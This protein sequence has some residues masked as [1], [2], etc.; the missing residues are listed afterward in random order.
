MANNEWIGASQPRAEVDT[1]TVGGTPAVSNTIAVTRNRK[2]VRYTLTGADTTATAAAALAE[3]LANSEI[4]E[5]R[6]RLWTYPGTGAV[7]TSTATVP[8]VPC[9]FATN[10]TG[11]GATLTKSNTVTSKGPNHADD[12]NNWS[13]GT[14]P[15]ATETIVI[16]RGAAILYGIDTAFAEDL[17]AFI[18]EAGFTEAIGL[19]RENPAGYAEDRPRYA[20]LGDATPFPVTIGRGPGEGSGQ[21]FLSVLGDTGSAIKVY[22]TGRR[23]DSDVPSLCLVVRTNPADSLDL[24]GGDVGTDFEVGQVSA[25]DEVNLNG[26]PALH[27]GAGS[28]VTA[29]NQYG[30]SVVAWGTVGAVV[31]NSGTYTQWGGSLAS[32]ES[33]GGLLDLRHTGTV[34][35]LN[36]RGNGTSGADRTVC[37]VSADSRDLTF[38][39]SSFKNGARLNDPNER[40][41]FTNDAR[42]D[43]ASLLASDLGSEFGVN[44]SA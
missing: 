15:A 4:A 31:R 14:A 2:E 39:N 36:C 29:L 11:G 25:F 16:P 44:R 30:G 1:Y 17:A 19:P 20:I 40:L 8:G 13:L 10:A 22:T 6:E 9:T 43:R 42:F 28:T 34:T 35:T 24:S 26:E 37:D 5:F 32:A 18:V 21:M 3:L 38:T 33:D 23:S 7:I 12:A 41:V 27:V